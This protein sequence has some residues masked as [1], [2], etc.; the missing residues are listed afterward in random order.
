MADDS[1]DDQGGPLGPAQ[2]LLATALRLGDRANDAG[3]PDG[4]AALLACAGRLARK[5]RGLSEV[6][7]F[8]L[9]RALDEAE[10]EPD[11]AAQLDAL[12]GGFEALFE[13]DAGEPEA[14]PDDPLGAVQAYI[15]MAISIGA[16]AYNTGDRQGCYDVY[17]A[18]GR[19]IVR[20]VAA[21]D[22]PIATIRDALGRCEGMSD[23]DDQAWAMRRAFD[24][25]LEMG[26]LTGEGIA[27]REI[28]LMLSLAIQ[29]GA[30][31]FNLG[32]RRGCYE[33]YACTARLLVNSSAVPEEVKAPLRTA[34]QEAVVIPDV[35]RQAWV[36]RH[37]F[38]KLIGVKEDGEVEKPSESDGMSESD[39][40]PED[41]QPT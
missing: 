27:P 23:A 19:M 34:L 41:D 26:A 10:N 16:P 40:P 17:A 33:V 21:A 22:E 9:E 37:A 15:G 25:I 1:S 18:T 20:T 3:D 28:R 11:P 6:A 12:R 5:V 32:D 24:S 13:D 39:G 35:S 14:I 36:M 8:R 29:I 38:D 7:D 30:P 2:P 31:A 4:A